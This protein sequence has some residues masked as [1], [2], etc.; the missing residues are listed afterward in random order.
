MRLRRRLREGRYQIEGSACTKDESGEG[1]GLVA[2]GGLEFRGVAGMVC[3]A[4][5][6]RKMCG[7]GNNESRCRDGTS[8]HAHS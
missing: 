6:L 5:S 1:T 4:P 3:V 2:Q 7:Y 8:V